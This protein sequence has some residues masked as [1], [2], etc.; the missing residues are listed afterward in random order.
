MNEEERNWVYEVY[1]YI[2]SVS[3]NLV[4][5]AD[6]HNI[7][8]DNLID[9]FMMYWHDQLMWLINWKGQS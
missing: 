6:E 7:D 4:K 9:Y 8:R 2:I 3:G 1:E 5:F